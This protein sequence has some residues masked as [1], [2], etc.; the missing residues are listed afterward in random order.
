MRGVAFVAYLYSRTGKAC[1]QPAIGNLPQGN[2]VVSTTWR[3]INADARVLVVFGDLYELIVQLQ[4]LMR[5]FG[6]RPFVDN[7]FAGVQPNA[8]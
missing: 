8:I 5:V 6:S 3:Y 2:D 7:V 4:L 1:H